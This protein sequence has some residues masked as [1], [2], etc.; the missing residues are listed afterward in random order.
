M[1]M[2]CRIVPRSLEFAFGH[3][4]SLK[5]ARQF[6]CVFDVAALRS[7]ISA[8]KQYRQ[9]A[10]FVSEI[11]AIARSVINTHFGYAFAHGSNVTWIAESHSIDP[12]GNTCAS[13]PVAEF[14]NPQVERRRFSDFD[15][16]LSVSH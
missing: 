3:S 10:T 14:R 12:D 16:G 13:L 6:K 9:F 11:D 5:F 2:V 7:F 8:G 4:Q 15:H 1:Q